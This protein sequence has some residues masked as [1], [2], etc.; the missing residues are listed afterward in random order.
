MCKIAW[1]T[2]THSLMNS[3]VLILE[4]NNRASKWLCDAAGSHSAQTHT[5]S[6]NLRLSPLNFGPTQLCSTQRFSPQRDLEQ[7]TARRCCFGRSGCVT[8]FFFHFSPVFRSPEHNLSRRIAFHQRPIV[9]CGR[10][11]LFFVRFRHIF[12]TLIK[13]H[14][15]HI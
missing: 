15:V 2:R 8:F 10:C 11:E 13:E 4:N 9:C 12:S 7:C 1:R 6:T 14:L 3:P 5:L